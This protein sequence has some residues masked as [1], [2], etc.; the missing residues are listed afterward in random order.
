LPAQAKLAQVQAV[1]SKQVKVQVNHIPQFVDRAPAQ[2]HDQL[3]NAGAVLVECNA[4][5]FE[6]IAV[7]V[8]GVEPDAGVHRRAGDSDAVIEGDVLVAEARCPVN[9]RREVGEPCR[10]VDIRYGFH[11]LPLESAK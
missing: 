3:G 11:D 9:V 5:D 4:Q 7:G 10:F 1:Q 6:R 2:F 8:A